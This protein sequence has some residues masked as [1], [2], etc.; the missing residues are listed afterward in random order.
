M[1]SCVGTTTTAVIL[2]CRRKGIGLLIIE[3]VSTNEIVFFLI[4]F[5]DNASDR[6]S[7]YA[8]VTIAVVVGDRYGEYAEVWE[9]V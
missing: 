3:G 7:F 9:A 2:V 4:N 6:I 8:T 5:T 1:S